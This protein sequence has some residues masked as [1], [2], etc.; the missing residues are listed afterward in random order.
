MRY[1]IDQ[2]PCLF[3]GIDMN[4][5]PLSKLATLSV[6]LCFLSVSIASQEV[7]T[8]LESREQVAKETAQVGFKNWLGQ[9]TDALVSSIQGKKGD[10]AATHW[11]VL[12][13]ARTI[14]RIYKGWVTHCLDRNGAWN[15]SNHR[16]SK[17]GQE[18]IGFTWMFDSWVDRD[19]ASQ[20]GFEGFKIW[21]RQNIGVVVDSLRDEDGNQAGTLDDVFELSKEILQAY[22]KSVR[23]CTQQ[24]G[25]WD[26]SSH[27]CTRVNQ[28]LFTF[29]WMF[30]T[31]TLPAVPSIPESQQGNRN[32]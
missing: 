16:C 5:R 18:L 4:V 15:T 14:H 28:E 12:T 9:N 19:I 17:D 13:S 30:E 31:V 7:Q 23:Q 25:D 6:V 8:Q 21:L 2:Y 10:R 26:T 32:G 11:D 3:P 22:E 27:L 29:T 20:I 24:K 1:R